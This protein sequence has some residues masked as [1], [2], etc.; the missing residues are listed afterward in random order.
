M[1]KDQVDKH[2]IF[3]SVVGSICYGTN[4]PESDVD[5][6]GVA[7]MKDLSYYYGWL[8]KFN[9]YEDN[10]EDTVIYDIRKAFKLMSDSN[11]NMLDLLYVDEKF[12]TKITPY[13]QTVLDN[14]DAFLSKKAR[15]TYVGYAYAQLKKIKTSRS[16]LLNP[17]KKKPERADFGLPEHKLIDKGTAGA[18]LWVLVN[19]L[20]GSIEHLNLSASAKE[21]LT[22]VNWI[23]L[24]QSKGITDETTDVIQDITGASDAWIE[25]MK[26]EQSYN[27]A[28]QSWNSYSSWKKSR[29]NKRAELEKKFGY[30][31]KHASH[32]VRLLRMGKEI[33]GEGKVK[34]YR[35]D[36][37]ELL[38]IRRGAW[39]YDELAE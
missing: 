16:W 19:L 5:I 24:A 7:V 18:Y 17:P 9:Q 34:V 37:E 21:E 15:H 4:T 8:N 2:T 31:T 25:S 11:P 1:N 6:R 10:V 27:H 26:K 30:D 33:M 36:R 28:Q 3:A 32:L 12:F 39:S 23:G 29:N 14:R 22:N 20:E 35:P 13:W 38:A